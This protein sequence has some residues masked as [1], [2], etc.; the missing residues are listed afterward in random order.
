MPIHASLGDAAS[1]AGA[2]SLRSLASTQS[3][4]RIVTAPSSLLARRL[5]Q[6]RI[7][8]PIWCGPIGA[9]DLDLPCWP[10]A[11]RGVAADFEVFETDHIAVT[12]EPYKLH[13]WQR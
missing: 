6:Q 7:S 1:G 10:W 8:P 13:A 9:E 5:G 12:T 11:S 3:M 4:S 2:D